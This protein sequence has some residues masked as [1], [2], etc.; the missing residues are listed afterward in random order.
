MKYIITPANELG[1]LEY[2]DLY[3]EFGFA[4][5][6]MLTYIRG[7]IAL[8]EGPRPIKELMHNLHIR[9]KRKLKLWN[10]LLEKRFIYI[11]NDLVFEEL[12]INNVKKYQKTAES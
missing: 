3:K 10:Y 8:Y 2:L 4:G 1:S 5:L 9:G 7:E 6:G 12:S 11:Q